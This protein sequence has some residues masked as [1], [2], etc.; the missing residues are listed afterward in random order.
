MLPWRG[1][2]RALSCQRRHRFRRTSIAR[3]SSSASST[4]LARRSRS[5]RPMPA[6]IDGS[7]LA[8]DV[9]P[10]VL[11]L[12]KVSGT[13]GSDMPGLLI[14][15]ARPP[16]VSSTGPSVHDFEEYLLSQ[17]GISP[18]VAA[19]IRAL[20][21]PQSTLPVPV[22]MDF[23][24]ART[25][26]VRGQSG[27]LLGDSTAIFSVVFW[28]EGNAVRAVGGPLTDAEVMDIANSLQ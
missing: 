5:T 28:R 3:P 4:P 21:D 10:V 15:D 23:A 8:V 6:N 19:Q 14:V 13:H 12:Y 20:G 9:G 27:L 25:V 11:Q 22:P 2:S 18:T 16:V 17:P 26:T 1:R 7:S 24:T